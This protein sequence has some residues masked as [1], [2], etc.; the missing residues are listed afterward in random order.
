MYVIRES[1]EHHRNVELHRYRK[2][3]LLVRAFNHFFLYSPLLFPLFDLAEA[4]LLTHTGVLLREENDQGCLPACFCG[5]VLQKTEVVRVYSLVFSSSSFPLSF[6]LFLTLLRTHRWP[7]PGSYCGKKTI[8]AACQHV[9]VVMWCKK[10]KSFAFILS[11]YP[12]FSPFVFPFIF[13][14][15]A[16]LRTHRWP[17]PGF[18]CGRQTV[19]A[20]LTRVFGCAVQKTEVICVY[21]IILSFIFPFV[22]PFIFPSFAFVRTHRWP[23]PGSYCGSQTVK[24]TL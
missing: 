11:F 12:S 2:V 14:S 22:F 3:C 17:A 8:K 10:P 13:P 23:A 9:Y 20:T 18:Y 21:S 4:A 15:F 5:Y 19:K 7:P 1:Q 16:F 24:A 6:P